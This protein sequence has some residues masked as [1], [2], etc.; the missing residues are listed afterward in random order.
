MRVLRS[1]C[2]CHACIRPASTA[3]GGWEG[4][5]AGSR[6]LDEED[7]SA[8][9]R[10]RVQHGPRLWQPFAARLRPPNEEAG[11]KT[12]RETATSPAATVQG[13][14]TRHTSSNLSK[15]EQRCLASPANVSYM[16]RSSSD[17][18]QMPTHE[19][20]RVDCLR[21]CGV[22][23]VIDEFLGTT[24]ELVTAQPSEAYIRLL[25]GLS[26]MTRG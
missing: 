7:S 22:L 15:R 1:G 25:G 8:C 16:H 13:M 4:W 14:L 3:T 24:R 26:L 5:T 19:A 6:A 17:M 23:C 20:G 12:Q 9:R 10:Q 18:E 21:V 2:P 11:C